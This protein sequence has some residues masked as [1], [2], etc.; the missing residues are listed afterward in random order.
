MGKPDEWTSCKRKGSRF[1]TEDAAARAA[2]DLEQ[3]VDT[4]FV[5]PYKCHYCPYWH[6]G[7]KTGIRRRIAKSDKYWNRRQYDP[8]LD[9]VL[10]PRVAAAGNRE[11]SGSDQARLH[12]LLGLLRAAERRAV[13]ASWSTNVDAR[14]GTVKGSEFVGRLRE[15]SR[16]PEVK[17]TSRM[18]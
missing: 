2:R 17:G 7:H 13:L 4:T 10:G 12:Y 9:E 3:R 5:E 11:N 1:T 14:P 8:T 16:H 18:F 6:V 15:V